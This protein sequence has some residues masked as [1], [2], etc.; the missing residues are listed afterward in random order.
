MSGNKPGDLQQLELLQRNILQSMNSGL[1]TI[2]EDGTVRFAN[3]A[4]QEILG[5]PAYALRGSALTKL[6]PALDLRS[7]G[8]GEGSA[9]L[10]ARRFATGTA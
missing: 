4:A 2:A 5:L 6:F 8:G 1:L 7:P 3:R 10:V 9:P